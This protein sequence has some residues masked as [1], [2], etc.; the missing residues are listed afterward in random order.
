MLSI[1]NLDFSEKIG[2]VVKLP[3]SQQ[4]HV[5]IFPLP[6]PSKSCGLP[7]NFT[8]EKSVISVT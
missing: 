7:F 3:L 5:Q 2:K 8:L 4:E 6:S 1:S